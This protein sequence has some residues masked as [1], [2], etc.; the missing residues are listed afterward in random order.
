MWRKSPEANPS[1]PSGEPHFPVAAPEA[2]GPA[3]TVS[4]RPIPPAGV[5]PNASWINQGL[6]FH[7]V[8][9]GNSDLYMDGELQGKIRLKQSAVSIG[10]NGKVQGDVHAR[11]IVVKG[12]LNGNVQAGAKT[13]LGRTGRV[14]GDILGKCV[15]IE[16][17]AFFQGRVDMEGAEEKRNAAGAESAE[18]DRE[19][20]PMATQAREGRAGR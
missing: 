7:G 10:P 5:G 8:F 9:S 13:V 17:G 1:S 11:E 4:E 3:S 14:R 18:E 2:R 19:V 16:E 12:T 20:Q 15:V 6:R